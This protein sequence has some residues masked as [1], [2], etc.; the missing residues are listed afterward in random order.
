MDTATIFSLID[1]GLTLI[2][3]LVEAGQSVVDTVEKLKTLNTAAST[4]QQVSDEDLAS[5]E[6][7]FDQQMNNFNADI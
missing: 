3:Y 7:D 6:A 2:P 1:K 4:G 5:L